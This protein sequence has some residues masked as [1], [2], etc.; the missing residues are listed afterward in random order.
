MSGAETSE[1]P[2]KRH[3]NDS[4]PNEVRRRA[5]QTMGWEYVHGLLESQRQELKN[6]K[7]ELAWKFEEVSLLVDELRTLY[8]EVRQWR[9]I[10][11]QEAEL[12]KQLLALGVCDCC[13][14]HAASDVSEE[15][16]ED[17]EDQWFN[18]EWV[19]SEY[20]GEGD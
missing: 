3:K 14:S 15:E 7:Q 16:G 6:T 2:L 10:H 9:Q 11:Q 20:E 8:H 17:I 4:Y 5:L 18:E 1:R 12:K 13:G 19:G